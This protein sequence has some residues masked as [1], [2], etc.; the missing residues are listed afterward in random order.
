MLY[1]SKIEVKNAALCNIK[2]NIHYVNSDG[3]IGEKVQGLSESFPKGD[4]KTYKFDSNSVAEGTLLIAHAFAVGS[5]PDQYAYGTEYV[6]YAKESSNKAK[7]KVTGTLN[8]LNSI[9]LVG[10]G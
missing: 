6:T 2:T 1:V 7:Y 9:E 4:S 3:T 8:S 10:L 5:I